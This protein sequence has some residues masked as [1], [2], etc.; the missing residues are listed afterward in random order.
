MRRI[1]LDAADCI[2]GYAA[3]ISPKHQAAAL[4]ADWENSIH[5][6][7]FGI[8]A[9]RGILSTPAPS[10]VKYSI[11]LSSREEALLSGFRLPTICVVS[12]QAIREAG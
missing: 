9:Q 6:A 2:A 11:V 7:A 12:G 4:D 10:A 5:G 3:S 8:V 1:S